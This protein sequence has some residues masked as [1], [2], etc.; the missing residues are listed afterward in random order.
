MN[1]ELYIFVQVDDSGE[2]ILLEGGCPWKDHLFSLETEL[3]V[4][5]PIKFAL[6][7]D[8][9]SKWRVQVSKKKNEHY[10]YNQG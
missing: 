2:V 5:V 10:Y 6:Y 8:S 1:I 7:T 9:N 4:D 3:S